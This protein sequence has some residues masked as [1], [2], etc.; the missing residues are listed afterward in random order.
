MSLKFFARAYAASG[1][2]AQPA[3]PGGKSLRSVAKAKLRASKAA[4][5][6]YLASRARCGCSRPAAPC[7]AT[8]L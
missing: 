3:R 7:R 1:T 4:S 6:A 5:A 2:A 8:S